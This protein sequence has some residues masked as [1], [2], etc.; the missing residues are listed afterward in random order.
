MKNLF[1]L[2]AG[3]I[4]LSMACTDPELDP[5]QYDKITKGA[6]LAL[7][8]TAV[9]IIS[10]GANKGAVDTW[11]KSFDLA[12]ENFEIDGEFLSAD[13]SSLAEVQIYA[14]ASATGAR[15]RVATVAGSTFS[16]SNVSV[17]PT[18]YP[19][20]KISIPLNT[21]LS[22]LSK[23]ASDFAT[24]SYIYIECDMLLTNGTVVPASAIVNESL[25]ASFHFLPANNC[26]YLVKD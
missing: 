6:V 1:F 18:D 13:P 5:L 22:A 25:F 4:V 15:V 17:G 2:L 26:L 19:Y 21:I 24:G 7:R 10:D 9:A 14:R 11:S 16:T 12:N 23:S 20:G 3:M 8:G